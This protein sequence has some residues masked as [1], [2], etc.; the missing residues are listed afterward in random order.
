MLYL[1]HINNLYS[2]FLFCQTVIA[3]VNLC[4]GATPDFLV[5]EAIKFTNFQLMDVR[6]HYIQKLNNLAAIYKYCT[7]ENLD[8]ESREQLLGHSSLAQF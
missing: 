1:L 2:Y 7:E 3:L 6:V 5:G 4:K 8:E